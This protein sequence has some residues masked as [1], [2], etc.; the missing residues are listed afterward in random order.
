MLQKYY[1]KEYVAREY[2]LGYEPREPLIWVLWEYAIK[3]GKKCR[4]KK[5][6][7]TSTSEMYYVG[8]YVIQL[9]HGQG[10]VIRLDKIKERQNGKK[11]QSL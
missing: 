1:S 10:S 3:Y 6:A 4:A 11:V 2:K 9:M 5:Y 8:S 7:N